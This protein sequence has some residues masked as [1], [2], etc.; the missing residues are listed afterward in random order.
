M[1]AIWFQFSSEA[2]DKIKDTIMVERVSPITN[3]YVS[4]PVHS[5]FIRTSLNIFRLSFGDIKHLKKTCPYFGTV[6][7]TRNFTA[8][9]RLLATFLFAI[10]PNLLLHYLI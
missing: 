1:A 5:S 10:V 8:E 2:I 9:N 4:C 6:F 7:P 3:L